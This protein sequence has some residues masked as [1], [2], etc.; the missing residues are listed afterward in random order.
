MKQPEFEFCMSQFKVAIA[1]LAVFILIVLYW[2]VATCKPE[3]ISRQHVLTLA[4]ANAP[5]ASN[6]PMK[7]KM[8]HKYWGNCN[9][10]HITTNVPS[11]PVSQ[12]F[13]GPP[14]TVS[15]PMTHK[16]WGNCNMCHVVTGGFKPILQRTGRRL[17]AAAVPGEAAPPIAANARLTHAD[18]GTC[19]N[20][21]PIVKKTAAN[22]GQRLAA[23]P[24][25]PP[26]ITSNAKRLH[27]DYGPCNSCH[28]IV[29]R[30][31]G[32]ANGAPVAFTRYSA[33]N[34]G[35]KL[36]NVNSA[37]MGKWGLADEEGVLVL[38]VGASSYAETAGL[39]RGDEIIRLNDLRIDTINDFNNTLALSQPKDTIKIAIY[40]GR[41]SRNIYIPLEQ[42][43]K[44]AA[45]AMTQNRIETLAEQYGVPKTQAAVQRA[46]QQA[47]VRPVATVMNQNRIET[48][49]EQYGVPKTQ[50]A[51]QRAIQQANVRPVAT[52]MTQNQI[53]T[54][55]EQ[56][57]VPKTQSAVQRAIQQ[58]RQPRS[59]T[60]PVAMPNKGKV[61]VAAMGPGLYSQTSLSFEKSPYFTIYDPVTNLY[62]SKVNPNYSDT[63]G[64]SRQSSHLMVDL[65]ASN[66]I[67]GNFSTQSANTMKLLHLNLY[68]G[69]TGSVQDVLNLYRSG[70][71]QPANI[72]A[73]R[74]RSLPLPNPG[75]MNGTVRAG[76]IF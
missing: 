14:I 22:G 29:K 8:T 41:K 40:R 47:N 33:S 65:G 43:V 49:A 57:R 72:N 10:C 64:N 63:K 12:V 1:V 70:N 58:A 39:K 60:K 66:I 71:I 76:N 74:M 7:A 6:I 50:A 36:Q 31:A 55:A 32:A 54:L 17:A 5:P 51:V 52:I 75:T 42:P 68:S 16:D 27:P 53:E 59:V 26:P 38:G 18:W 37:L 62:K 45:A 4:A 30:T 67:A 3:R 15:A 44:Q 2:A 19:S 56:Y 35:L 13:Q 73:S 23:A 9:M 21:H 69:V 24:G 46:I 48:L 20:C 25:T 28:Q 34:L 11:K 61:I